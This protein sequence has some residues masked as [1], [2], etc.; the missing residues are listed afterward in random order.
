MR[1]LL[2][3]AVLTACGSSS[4]GDDEANQYSSIEV[5]PAF[6]SVTVAIG[7]TATQDYV[8]YGITAAGK[9]D[10]TSDCALAI[11]ATFGSFAG[12]T[13]TVGPHGGKTGITATCGMVTG[14]A[15]LTVNLTGDI[16]QP[17][18]PDSAPGLFGAATAGADPAR[19]PAI[20][21]PLHN[22]VSPRN[23]PPIEVQWTASAND[24]FKITLQSTFV[25]VNVYTTSLES[26]VSEVDWA[27]IIESSAG[28]NLVI[29]VEGLAQAAPTTKFASAPVTVRIARDTID[30]TAIYWWASSQGNIM[31][32]TFG[33][34][35]APT[36][37]KDDCTSCHS[38]SR[39]GTRIGYSRCVG[40]DMNTGNTNACSELYAGFMKYNPTTKAFDDIVNARD[41]TIQG[42]YS[43]FSPVGNPFPDDT[44]ALAIVSTLPGSKLSLYDPDTGAPV[45]SNIEAQSVKGPGEP[46]SATMPDWSPDGAKIAFAST[47]H[48]NQW[49]DISDSRI[50]TMSYAHTGG[51]HVFGDPTL[52]FADPITLQNGTY[53]SFFFPSYSPDGQLLVFNAAKQA[54]R[55]FTDARIPGQRLML[56]D[57][58]GAW[59]VDMPAMN[60]GYV[61]RDITWARWAPTVGSDYY[62]IVF[63]SQHDYGHR[64]TE[65]NSFSGCVANGVRQC[66][67]L[68]IGAVARNQLTG[69]V[70]PSAPPMWLPGQDM[71]ADNISPYWTVPTQLQ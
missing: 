64:I 8:V 3:A 35:T 27:N 7:S 30:R 54:W 14:E 24:L 28:D 23:M 15:V 6:S 16:V 21:Y 38:V 61:D 68:W 62:W 13:V 1:Y 55:N 58:N 67:Q 53:T 2:F 26:L 71:A 56:A 69:T 47:P 31:T 5:E 33:T 50:A 57:A 36:L 20:E 63:S 45:A 70:D 22:A 44:Q 19:T 18:A 4:G 39:A 12:A 32:Q 42:S 9:Q 11:D 60:G 49:I 52:L 59:V 48:A 65:A 17:P 25:S 40:F 37:V 41:K 66:K 10:V 46:R 43:T 29:T 51:Q 34:L